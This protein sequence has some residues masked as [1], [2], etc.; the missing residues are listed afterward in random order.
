[1]IY[2]SKSPLYRNRKTAKKRGGYLNSYTL[3]HKNK[4]VQQPQQKPGP[5]SAS[6]GRNTTIRRKPQL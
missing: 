3:S 6:K 1:M 2:M 4:R 5:K